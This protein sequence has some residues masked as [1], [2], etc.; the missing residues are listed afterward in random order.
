MHVE[1]ARLLIRPWTHAEADRLLDIQ[2]RL[3]VVKWLGDGEPQL[4]KDLDE[5]HARIDRYAERDHP[6][7]GM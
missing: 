7:L 4:M 3:E 2:S 1:T 6:P 5:A